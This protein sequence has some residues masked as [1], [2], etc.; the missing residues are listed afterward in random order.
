MIGLRFL[1]TGGLGIRPRNKFSRDYRRFSTLLVDEHII[2]DPSEDIF[3]FEESFM[4]SGMLREVKEAF[5]T[6]SHLDHFSVSAIEKLA[7]SGNLRVYATE[8]LKEELSSVR[9]I[10]LVL[11]IP[12]SLVRIGKYSILPLPANHKTDIKTETALN[13]LI[14]CEGKTVFYGIDGSFINPEAWHILKEIKLDAVI[15]DCALAND[16]YSQAS[17]N[18]NNLAAAIA[19]KDV[20]LSANVAGENTKFILSHIP[21]SKK[22]SIHD[23]LSEAVA[24]MPFKIAYD[25]YFIGI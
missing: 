7:K 1:G 15:L 10:E 21:T 4:L 20:F 11:L 17:V 16:G 5:I 12:F 8:A 18:H 19:V 2:I 3:E 14:E 13:F 6:H 24:D 23:E 9:G 25:G 22:H